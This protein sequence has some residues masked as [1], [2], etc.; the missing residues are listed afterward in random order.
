M[1]VFSEIVINTNLFCVENR[2]IQWKR[3]ETYLLWDNWL[4]YFKVFLYQNLM[5]ANW[6]GSPR[7]WRIFSHLCFK[8]CDMFACFFV[9][10][11]AAEH[12]YHSYLIALPPTFG[13]FFSLH[14]SF[15]FLQLSF[16]IVVLLLRISSEV[17]SR[18]TLPSTF[19]G[20]EINRDH[21][22]FQLFRVCFRTLYL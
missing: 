7:N 9:F 13:T 6:L 1:A 17:N 11:G 20:F 5:R 22:T 8:I 14:H 19:F 16:M 18:L 15:S 12:N 21:T 10:T 4:I 2:T 3:K